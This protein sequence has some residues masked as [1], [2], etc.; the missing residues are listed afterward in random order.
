MHTTNT[1][2]PVDADDFMVQDF[3][4][5]RLNNY[6]EGP[7]CNLPVQFL[8]ASKADRSSCSVILRFVPRNLEINGV[9]NLCNKYGQVKEVG[10]KWSN[11]GGNLVMELASLA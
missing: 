4:D 3:N 11:N 7:G 6:D 9:R 2:N 1:G 10:D 5:P 8:S